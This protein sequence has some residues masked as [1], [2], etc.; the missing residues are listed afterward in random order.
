[1]PRF[2]S[3]G[4]EWRDKIQISNTVQ[5]ICPICINK[6]QVWNRPWG[7]IEIKYN[8][9]R[10]CRSRKRLLDLTQNYW[11]VS[12]RKWTDSQILFD[13]FTIALRDIKL[14][15]TKEEHSVTKAIW[16][17]PGLLKERWNGG[18]DW[19]PR[20]WLYNKTEPTLGDN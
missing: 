2:S 20:R 14:S 4:F 16:E 18:P 15:A 19:T 12:A 6:N 17:N 3:N 9:S 7:W 10:S 1:M 8:F 5:S 11:V 13:S